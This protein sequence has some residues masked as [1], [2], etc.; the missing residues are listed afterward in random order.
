MKEIKVSV[1]GA[2]GYTA[3]ELLR[4]LVH[5]PNVSLCELSSNSQQGKKIIDVHRDLIGET[6]LSFVSEIKEP[7]DVLFICSGH[8]KS[9]SY[10]NSNYPKAKKIIDLSR[11]FRLEDDSK[12]GE[13]QFVYGLPEQHREEIKKADAIANPGCFATAM[14]LALLPLAKEGLLEKDVHISGITGSTGAGQKNQDTT[15]YSWR[16]QNV[17]TYK[18]FTHQHIDE[19]QQMLKQHGIE[20]ISTHF[21]PYRGNFTRGIMVNLYTDCSLREEELNMLYQRYYE[22]HPLTH[23]SHNG[24][25]LKQ[26]TNTAKALISVEKHEG[27]AFVSCAIDNLLK[28]ASG[29][30]VQNMNLMFGLPETTGIQLKA[31]YF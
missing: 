26:V 31:N 7:C 23:L 10:L 21:I 28:G 14:Q 13:T 15:H 11:D 4:I 29:Q 6:E 27:K 1:V 17:S 19:V 3:G 16:S 22:N 24:I 2:A 5:H 30:A 9:R 12:H 25:D 8:G 18:T 20:D